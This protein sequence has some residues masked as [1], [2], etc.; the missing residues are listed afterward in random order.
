MPP[1]KSTPTTRALALEALRKVWEQ[2]RKPK[3]AIEELSGS[4]D[5]RERSFL[6][7]LVYGVLRYRDTLDWVL[8]EFVRKPSRLNQD[9]RNNLRLAAYQILFMRVQDWAAVNE[10][11]E[12]EKHRGR[13]EVVNGVLRSLLRKPV[14]ERLNLSPVERKGV[15]PYLALLTSHP[16]WLMKR[17]VKRFGEKGALEL[18]EANNRIPP[19]TLRVNTLCSTRE[20]LLERLSSLGITGE[21]SQFS[22]DGIRLKGSPTVKEFSSLKESF[23]VQDEAAQL[24]TYLLEPKPGERILDACASPGGKTTHIAQMIKDRGEILSLEIDERRIA[25]LKENVSNLNMTSITLLHRDFRELNKTEKGSFDRIL[26]DAPCSALGVIRRNPD[27]KYRRRPEDLTE[28]MKKQLAMLRAAAKMLKPGGSIVYSVCSTEP[29]EGEQV[30]KEF[31]KDSE[32]FYIIDTTIP[33]LKDFMKEGLFRTYPHIHDMDGF[34]GVK[35]CKR[36]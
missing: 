3:G 18:A 11:V 10:A 8:H 20:Q 30:V 27:I 5:S 36:V 14:T 26:L 22:P 6:M 12:L 1:I 2:D 16:S 31:L 17:W 34:F 33:F 35:L 32:D 24:I 21:P 15:V 19:L 28:F 9:T 4:L 7:E 29:E 25:Q 13:P 23:M